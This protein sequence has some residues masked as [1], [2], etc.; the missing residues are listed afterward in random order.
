M[1]LPADKYLIEALRAFGHHTGDLI[2]VKSSPQNW[3]TTIAHARVLERIAEPEAEQLMD[4][5]ASKVVI[6][7]L[8]AERDEALVRIDELEGCLNEAIARLRK[9]EPPVDPDLMLAREVA[10]KHYRSWG[11]ENAA[12]DIE[13]GL[14][15]G[16]GFVQCALAGIKAG[17]E[18]RGGL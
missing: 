16:N 9:H 4:A 6:D 12:R 5:G 1:T 3:S 14:D 17:L 11:A 15:D 18:L 8:I 7:Q 2:F 10:A 13:A